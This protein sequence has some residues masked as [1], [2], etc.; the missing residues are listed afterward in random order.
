MIRNYLIKQKQLLPNWKDK[1]SNYHQLGGIETS[2]LDNGAAK[3]IRIAWINTGSGLRYK[4]VL[5]RAMD[6]A[7]AFLNQYSLAWISHLGPTNPNFSETEMDW[8]KTFGGG[9]MVTCGLS[10]IGGPENDTTGKRGLHGR[11]SNQQAEIISI[12]QPDPGLGQ[13]NMSITG[14]IKE[15][16][17]FG[18]FLELK[19]T[20]SSTLGEAK[21]TIHD[22]VRNRGNEPVPHMILY[23][24][25]FGWPL[26][27]NGSII[28]WDGLWKSRGSKLDNEIFY[29]GGNFKT[30]KEPLE[31]HSGMGEACAFIDIKADDNGICNCGI[32][33]SNL[34]I[35]FDIRFKK[36]QLPWISNWQHWGI[37]EYVTALEPGTN[38]PIGQNKA[39]EEESL[40]YINPGEYKTYDLD[41]EVITDEDKIEA[42]LNNIKD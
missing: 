2:I 11:I 24:C 41:M 27:D 9:L 12:I 34:K 37:G 14:I 18:P 42:I 20:I 5:D 36:S 3:G 10:H 30:C 8:L 23:H 29:N 38:G 15:S 35:A 31:R 16:M 33:N 32:L 4:I 6:I 25:N 17:V 39:K 7:D 21:I 22:E 19:R 13:F 40:I 1:I 28:F 26:I